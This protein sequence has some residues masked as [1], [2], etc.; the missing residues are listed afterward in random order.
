MGEE[1]LSLVTA[2]KESKQDK[3]ALRGRG[4]K[5]ATRNV[6]RSGAEDP[7]NGDKRKG[8]AKEMEDGDRWPTP[9]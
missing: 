5:G 6:D 4:G 9:L 8:K 3:E 1:N 2:A 7:G